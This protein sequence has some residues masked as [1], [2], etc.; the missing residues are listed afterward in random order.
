M[1]KL[2]AFSLAHYYLMELFSWVAGQKR[3]SSYQLQMGDSHYVAIA[4]LIQ[5]KMV[6]SMNK[7]LSFSKAY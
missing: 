3:G 1:N 7:Y 4:T 2:M 5:A 6:T